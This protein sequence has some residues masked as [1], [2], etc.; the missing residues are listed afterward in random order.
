[1]IMLRICMFCFTR[2]NP[3]LI[4]INKYGLVY[5]TISLVLQQRQV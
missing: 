4:V 3:L 1:M 5:V 2:Y